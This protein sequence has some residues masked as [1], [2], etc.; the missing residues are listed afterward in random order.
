MEIGR[1]IQKSLRNS[2]S[3]RLQVAKAIH[4]S[5]PFEVFCNWLANQI[6]SR[7]ITPAEPPSKGPVPSDSYRHVVFFAEHIPFNLLVLPS[8]AW[9]TMVVSFSTKLILMFIPVRSAGGRLHGQTYDLQIKP[10]MLG[11]SAT[12]CETP[13]PECGW[14]VRGGSETVVKRRQIEAAEAWRKSHAGC[15]LHNACMRSFVPASGG[16]KNSKTLYRVM[17]RK[18]DN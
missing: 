7:Q 5:L 8:F 1:K 18:G 9:R 17:S 12:P 3:S 11:V 14:R 2:K 4:V 15:S 6:A 16:Y 10:P 13:L